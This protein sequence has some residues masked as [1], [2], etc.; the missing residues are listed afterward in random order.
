VSAAASATAILVAAGSGERLGAG[1][2]AF[3]V[4]AGQ[5]L[6][7]RAARALA[8]TPAVGAVV[9]VVGADDLGRAR[10][11]LDRVGLPGVACCAGGAT[12]QE[13]VRRGLEACPAGTAV[14][15]VHDAARPLASPSLIGRTLAALEDPWAAVAPGLPVVDTLKLVDETRGR[16]IRTLERH[17]V[18]GVQTPQ[19]FRIETLRAVHTRVGGDATD[20]LA[21]VEHAGGRVRLIEGERRNFKITYPDDLAIAEALVGIGATS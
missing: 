6:L 20:D 16:V 14:V 19:V 9:A 13:S 12:R 11:E 7:V 4:L 18:W 10:A 2:K 17:G 21:L 5:T 1:P 15:A 3:V 8:T